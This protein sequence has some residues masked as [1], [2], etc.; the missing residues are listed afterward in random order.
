MIPNS[1]TLVITQSSGNVLSVTENFGC[2]YLNKS[3]TGKEEHTY[4]KIKAGYHEESI[5]VNIGGIE[6]IWCSYWK[7]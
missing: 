6:N 1:P 4:V 2:K 5:K 3:A 7:K